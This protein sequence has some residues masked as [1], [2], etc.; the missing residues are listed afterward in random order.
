M[1]TPRQPNVRTPIE[2]IPGQ[3]RNSGDRRP[4][5]TSFVTPF[6]PG[7]KPAARDAAPVVTAKDGTKDR[8]P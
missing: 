7:S 8:S 2:Q 3:I 6:M 1:N 4:V 5:L